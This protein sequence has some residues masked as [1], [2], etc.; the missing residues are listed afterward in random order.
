M[1]CFCMSCKRS[2]LASDWF[3]AISACASWRLVFLLHLGLGKI[4]LHRSRLIWCLLAY[5]DGKVF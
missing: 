2:L 1:A 4:G 3:K 5:P